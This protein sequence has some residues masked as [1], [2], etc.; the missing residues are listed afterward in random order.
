MIE[1]VILLLV[2]TIALAIQVV[3]N[4]RSYKELQ[5]KH[6]Y[7]LDEVDKHRTALKMLKIPDLHSHRLVYDGE[8]YS[9]LSKEDIRLPLIQQLKIEKYWIPVIEKYNKEKLK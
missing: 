5:E 2:M 9:L 4:N 3:I 8:K 1:C 7:A 6:F